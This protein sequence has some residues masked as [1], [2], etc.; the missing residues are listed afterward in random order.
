MQKEGLKLIPIFNLLV[1]FENQYVIIRDICMKIRF[2]NYLPYHPADNDFLSG[3]LV[4]QITIDRFG[5]GN[6]R[7]V[8]LERPQLVQ[9][10]N[11]VVALSSKAQIE[12]IVIANSIG[13]AKQYI[14]E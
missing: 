8:F 12:H 13:V 6:L 4:F 1:G 14:I 9:D 10:L 7:V 2:V 11:V 3:H 5:V